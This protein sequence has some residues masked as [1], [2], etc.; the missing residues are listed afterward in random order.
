MTV[1][2]PVIKDNVV[3]SIFVTTITGQHGRFRS[4]PVTIT[5]DITVWIIG[6]LFD[7]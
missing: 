3:K 4:P 1:Y 7:F 2:E 6:F 5:V